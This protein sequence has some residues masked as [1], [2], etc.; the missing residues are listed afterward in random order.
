[1]T[2]STIEFP[3]GIEIEG[4]FKA[5]YEQ[6][7]TPEALALVAK[8]SRSF[9]ARRQELLAIRVQRAQRIDAGERPDFLP[10]TAAIRAADWRIA[11]IPADLQC[12]RVEITARW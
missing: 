9:E 2:T 8:L 12:R 10:E 4:E 5:D 1:M 6:I 7:L 11:P 3:A